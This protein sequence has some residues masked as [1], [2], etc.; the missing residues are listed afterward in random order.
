MHGGTGA[1]LTWLGSEVLPAFRSLPDP[2]GQPAAD[3]V[4]SGYLAA[5]DG[6]LTAAATS[7]PFD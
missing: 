3:A 1:T 4:A 2:A 7:L 6:H 5:L